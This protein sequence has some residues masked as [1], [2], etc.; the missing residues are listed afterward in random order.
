MIPFIAGISYE[1]LKLS[2]KFKDNII[3]KIVSMPG[4]LLQK[5]TTNNPSKKQIEVAIESV[6]IALKLEKTGKIKKS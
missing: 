5:I 6:K 3:L 1:L 2:S 4:L